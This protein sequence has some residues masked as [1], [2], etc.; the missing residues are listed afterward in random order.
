MLAEYSGY[1]IYE[2]TDFA[3]NQILQMFAKVG[4]VATIIFLMVVCYFTFS[5][6][7]LFTNLSI[8][9]CIIVA[10]AINLLLPYFIF[11]LYIYSKFKAYKK[12]NS[13]FIQSNTNIYIIEQRELFKQLELLALQ[14]VFAK[15]RAYRD[16]QLDVKLLIRANHFKIRNER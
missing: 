12:R 6:L 7:M 10:L 13:L 16:A 8:I 4:K 5:R 15:H 3:N 1:Q 11:E 14:D 2:A 9:N